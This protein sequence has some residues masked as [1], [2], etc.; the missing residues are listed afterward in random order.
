MWQERLSEFVTLFLV[1]D[2]IAV[3]PAF[4]T[5]AGSFDPPVQRK[6]ALSAVLVSFAVLVFFI[7]GGSFLLKQLGVSLIAFQISGGI[8]LFLFALAMVR[9]DSFVPP[10]GAHSHFALA[11]YPLAIPKIAGPASML[12]VVLLSDDD[13]YNFV[14]QLGTVGVLALVLLIQLA[15]LLAAGPISRVIGSAGNAVIGRVM[16]ILLA[17]LAV[18]IVLTAFQLWLGL[19]KLERLTAAV[20]VRRYGAAL[21]SRKCIGRR[22]ALRSVCW[23]WPRRARPWRTTISP[24]TAS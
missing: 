1:I 24:S 8:V 16:G 5:I 21:E 2:P 17:A 9:G 6:I 13:R 20:L 12:A 10:G 23:R 4:L 7:F 19:P 14:E 18:N 22:G 11:V 3:V 15:L